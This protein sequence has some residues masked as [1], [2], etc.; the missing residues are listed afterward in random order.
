MSRSWVCL[1]LSRY[2]LAGGG[3]VY[4]ILGYNLVVSGHVYRL[5]GYKQVV[6]GYA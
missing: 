5:H 1:K 3:Y 4:T 2:N 6:V